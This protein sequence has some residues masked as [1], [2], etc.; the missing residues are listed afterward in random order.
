MAIPASAHTGPAEQR[1]VNRL[2]ERGALF[3]VSHSGG[4]DSQAMTLELARLVP[5]EQMIVIHAPLGEVEWSGTLAHIEATIPAGVPL[6]LAPTASG[7]TLLERIEERGKFPDPKRR[8]CTSDFK[9]GPIEREIRRYL[10]HHPRFGGQ[11]VSTLG[12]RAEESLSRAKQASW[13]RHE[14]AS[15]AGRQWFTWLPIFRLT[16]AQVFDRIRD[17]RQTPHWIYS[18]LNRCS[19]SFCIFGSRSD[20]RTA[21]ELRP[22]L[23]A[24]YA[25]LEQRLGH[26]LSPSRTPLPQ[27]TGIPAR[28]PRLRRDDTKS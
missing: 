9:T 13:S 28:A 20:L 18:Y 11:V 14:R 2:L 24:K 21:A 4:K 12:I 22:D 25:A 19:C 8:F 17:A 15:R 5:P 6:L 26:T 27:L 7:K 1:A 3:A 23:Y 16:T 10:M